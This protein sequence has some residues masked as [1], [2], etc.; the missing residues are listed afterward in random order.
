MSLLSLSEYRSSLLAL[1]RNI[2][3]PD[4]FVCSGSQ[5]FAFQLRPIFDQGR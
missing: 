3:V 1:V 2:M 5:M 4:V